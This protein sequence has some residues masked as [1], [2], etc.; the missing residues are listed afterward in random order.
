MVRTPAGSGDAVRR[1]GITFLVEESQ[2]CTLQIA[3]CKVGAIL[4]RATCTVQLCD[5]SSCIVQLPV[6]AP[7]ARNRHGL[8]ANEA[9]QD[10]WAPGK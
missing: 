6:A 10:H 9:A 3:G 4:Q 2:S 1:D 5:Y 7:S 8:N